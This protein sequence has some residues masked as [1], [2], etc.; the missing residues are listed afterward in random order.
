MVINELLS[1]LDSLQEENLILS[2]IHEGKELI[3]A[4]RADVE[5]C[6]RNLNI[7]RWSLAFT[8]LF[9]FVIVFAFLC[10]KKMK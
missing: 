8:W 10:M 5:K 6:T 7:L 3:G 4:V 1:I 9:E 2:E